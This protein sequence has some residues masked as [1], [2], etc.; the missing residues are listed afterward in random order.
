MIS[1]QV[2]CVFNTCE[3]HR[4]PVDLLSD[5]FITSRDLVLQVHIGDVRRMAIAPVCR[6]R[7][8]SG[9]HGLNQYPHAPWKCIVILLLLVFATSCYRAWLAGSS[10][11][12]AVNTL[13]ID[14]LYFCTL[15][16]RL[17][18]G[19]WRVCSFWCRRSLAESQYG[20]MG[21]LTHLTPPKRTDRRHPVSSRIGGAP[22]RCLLHNDKNKGP[23]GTGSWLSLQVQY[24]LQRLNITLGSLAE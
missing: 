21:S 22:G 2:C 13:L 5:T 19:G 14:Q 20:L 23:P 8:G 9:R 16:S 15:E 7:V 11:D 4:L 1:F 17:Y 3:R 6:V 12:L 10:R 18:W 24:C